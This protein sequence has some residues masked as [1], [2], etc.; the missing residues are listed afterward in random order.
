MHLDYAPD[1]AGGV[2]FPLLEMYADM[3]NGMSLVEGGA[4][5]GRSPT[6]SDVA[7]APW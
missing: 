3:L 1:V 5:G 6:S 7:A 4:G 2:V